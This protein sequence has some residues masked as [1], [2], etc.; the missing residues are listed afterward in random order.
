MLLHQRSQKIRKNLSTRTRI[1]SE[2]NKSGE[3]VSS[4]TYFYC[5]AYLPDLPN[6]SIQDR[7]EPTH[8]AELAFLFGH[9]LL[10]NGSVGTLGYFPNRK[11]NRDE[12]HLSRQ[13]ITYW[14][15]FIRTG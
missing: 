1:S 14:T 7:A 5:F 9:P 2:E 12:Q 8:G 15:N 10:S 13:I 4:S 6:Q 11:Y 3:P